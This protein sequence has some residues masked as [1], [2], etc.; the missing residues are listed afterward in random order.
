MLRRDLAETTGY[1]FGNPDLLRQALTHRSFGATHNERLE[2]L[3]DGVLNCVVAALLF[4]R[5]PQLPEGE[6]SRLRASLV[7]QQSLFETAQRIDLGRHLQLGEGEVKSGGAQR[8][9][10]LADALE[11]LIGAAFLDGGFDAARALVARLF[12]QALKTA[13]P[14]NVGKDAK[15]QLQ[16]FLQARRIALPQYSVIATG[17]EAHEQSFRV[18]CAIPELNIRTQGEGSSRRS[19]EQVAARRAYDLGSRT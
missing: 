10:I 17:G 9:S 3:G 18:E 11:A 14:Q 8:P 6:L 19:A 12:E 2:F 4:E 7:N 1:S 16:E 13:D 15:T 5:F